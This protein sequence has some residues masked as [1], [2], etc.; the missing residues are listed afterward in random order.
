MKTNH[1]HLIVNSIFE[2][3]QLIGLPKPLH[4]LVSLIRMDE[5][6]RPET[7]AQ[8][9][10]MLNFYCVTLKKNLKGKL[11]YGQNYYDFDE[12]VLGMMGP[13]QILSTSSADNYEVTGWWL[14]FHPDFIQPY[15]LGKQI[16]NYGFFSYDVHEALHLSEKEEQ[17][18]EDIMKNIAQ[19]YKSSIDAYSQ[20]VMIS[21]LEL[22]LN[23][24]NRYYN[25]QFITRKHLNNDLLSK[26][27]QLLKAYFDSE[28]IQDK[29][30]PTVQYLSQQLNL[31][32]SYLSDLLKNLTGQTAQQ[33]IH[34]HLILKAKELLS[35]TQLSVS[36]IAYQLGFEYPQSFSKLFKSKTTLTPLEYKQSFN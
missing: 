14:I 32:P 1:P 29:G 3:H 25:R 31:S 36:E 22:L 26:L 6:P 11:K 10:L 16:K 8:F 12:G 13:K 34:E 28:A 5:I 35:S 15:T 27:E 7:S 18:L 30:L 17:I 4:P 19:E 2:L 20:D 33:H 9:N 23:Y 21:H 24:S